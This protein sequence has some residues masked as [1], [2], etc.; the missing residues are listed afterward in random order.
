MYLKTTVF[1]CFQITFFFPL[2]RS[3]CYPL[4]NYTRVAV[5][6]MYYTTSVWI[7]TGGQVSPV[8]SSILNNT[9]IKGKNPN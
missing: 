4:L 6:P 1:R 8:T 5:S 9:E 7:A 2:C 3:L